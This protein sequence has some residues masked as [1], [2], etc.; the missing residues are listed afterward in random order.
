MTVLPAP[1]PLPGVR[2]D[3][4]G[5]F[6][7]YVHVPFCATRCG[8]CDFN[9]YTPAELGGANPDGWLAALNLRARRLPECECTPAATDSR[10]LLL[11]L[12]VW[13]R[14][15]RDDFALLVPRD[16]LL[17]DLRAVV[18]RLVDLRGAVV[19]LFDLRA[20]VLVPL[21][22][23]VALLAALFFFAGTLAPALRAS[24]RPIAIAC[25]R[26]LTVLPERPLFSVPRLRSCIAFSTLLDAFS[27]YL[28]MCTSVRF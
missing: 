16:L 12:L 11:L 26:L 13:V 6:G 10:Y 15:L 2:A 4:G 18:A 20:A 17:L 8:Y 25:L 7:I 24:D 27:P 3:S 22:L 5:P 14:L 9:T 19:R 21:V 1:A 23:R 28:A